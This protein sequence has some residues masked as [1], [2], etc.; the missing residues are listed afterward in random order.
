MTKEK[1]SQMDFVIKK[2]GEQQK[3]KEKALGKV[4]DMEKQMEKLKEETENK[5]TEWKVQMDSNTE[6]TEQAK[7][8]KEE[9]E[10]INRDLRIQVNEL[11]AKISAIT[12]ANQNKDLAA[13]QQVFN[14]A[15]EKILKELEEVRQA[16]KDLRQI[17]FQ[18]EQ[19]LKGKYLVEIK[20]L[21]KDLES[22]Q[23]EVKKW[24]QEALRIEEEKT[25]LE[26]QFNQKDAIIR[27][28]HQANTELQQLASSGSPPVPLPPPPGRSNES[29]SPSNTL[30]PP[31][32]L[33]SSVPPPSVTIDA[34]PPPPAISVPP[35]PPPGIPTPSSTD[36][37]PARSA[38]L[39]SITEGNFQLKKTTTKTPNP[40][41]EE[42]SS[43]VSKRS[44]FE[45]IKNPQLRKVEKAETVEAP[46]ETQEEK[47]VANILAFA[48][49][50]RRDNMTIGLD[51]NDLKD[52][53]DSENSWSD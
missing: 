45:A 52:E 32:V 14:E 42:P 4:S 47:T 38:L 44:L 10:E 28:L 34:P 8:Q 25:R 51:E 24:Q 15:K 7:K 33:S 5:I 29:S 43:G 31:P 30:P 2:L 41:T 36:T 6:I 16:K 18:E 13:I 48:I 40:I 35:P 37:P 27:Q 26:E 1:E 12:L 19:Q 3:L 21:K 23:E 39:N 50:A 49:L 46:K 11:T 53:S 9:V 17:H 20:M 22:S